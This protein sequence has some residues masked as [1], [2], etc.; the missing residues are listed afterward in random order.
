MTHARKDQSRRE[1]I[2]GVV[3]EYERSGLSRRRFC[4]R[5][6]VAVSTLDYWRRQVRDGDRA[7][8]VPVKIQA[9]EPALREGRWA[10]FQL[11][12]PNGVRIESGWEFP[13]LALARLPR[14]AAER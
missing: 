12:L 4:E 13:E 1:V 5:T 8:I 6:G 7:R 14:V 2:A 11:S 3:A 9:T 10:R